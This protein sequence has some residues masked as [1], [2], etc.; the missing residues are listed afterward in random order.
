MQPTLDAPIRTAQEKKLAALLAEAEERKRQAKERKLAIRYHRVR[1][2]ERV[3]LERRLKQLQ[4]AERQAA[5]GKAPPL[6]AADT[7]ELAQVKEDLEYVLH[8]P[9]GEKYVSLLKDAEDPAAQEHLIKERARLRALVKQQLAEEALLAEADEGRSRAGTAVAAVKSGL[10]RAHASLKSNATAGTDSDGGAEGGD[11]D[12]DFFLSEGDNEGEDTGESEDTQGS[13]DDRES[14]DEEEEVPAVR[15]AGLK[16]SLGAAE[17]SDAESEEGDGESDAPADDSEG[18]AEAITKAD[19]K[20]L[21]G[22]RE[23]APHAAKKRSQGYHTHFKPDPKGQGRKAPKDGRV[24]GARKPAGNG[25]GFKTR[26]AAGAGGRRNQGG[27]QPSNGPRKAAPG[28]K[29]GPKVA[30]KV[31]KAPLRTRA[32]GGRKRRKK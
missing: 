12:D 28:A 14:E 31:E 23:R 30:A 27:S 20:S 16:R 9:K 4:R 22:R 3:K 29:K 11:A 26:G 18:E 5:A 10:K 6:P 2:F 7:A 1:F 24:G 15:Q 8:Y 21:P 32:E 17:E 19:P 13:E 25:S